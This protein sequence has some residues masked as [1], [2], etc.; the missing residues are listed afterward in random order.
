MISLLLED[1]HDRNHIAVEF[2]IVVKVLSNQI[3]HN[4][5]KYSHF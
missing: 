3:D 4:I 1:H 5:Q 2:T